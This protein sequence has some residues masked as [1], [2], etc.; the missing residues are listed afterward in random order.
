M[1]VKYSKD[2]GWKV[3]WVFDHS[4]CYAAMSND[5][6]DVSK[7]NVNPGGKQRVMQDGL[8]DGKVKKMNYWLGFQMDCVWCW[9]RRVLIRTW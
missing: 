7:M 6:P 2:E 8:W 1:E 5:A 3:I 4:S 9:R